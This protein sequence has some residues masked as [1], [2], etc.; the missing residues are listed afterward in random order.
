MGKDNQQN[1]SCPSWAVLSF[2]IGGNAFPL[3]LTISCPT[4]LSLCLFTFR[5]KAGCSQNTSMSWSK[6]SQDISKMLYSWEVGGNQDAPERH[7]HFHSNKLHKLG[8]KLWIHK[9]LE[10]YPKISWQQ[11]HYNCNYIYKKK[12]IQL[13]QQK[14]NADRMWK[15]HN[16]HAYMYTSNWWVTWDHK[17]IRRGHTTNRPKDHFTLLCGTGL[18]G[19]VSDFDTLIVLQFFT[20][21]LCIGEAARI[22]AS[23]TLNTDP[24]AVLQTS[25]SKLYVRSF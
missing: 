17:L 23:G 20:V 8:N 10:V 25:P 4:S 16:I 19:L 6:H 24:A 5:A 13:M 3:Q 2:T 18:W 1:S 11:I 9:L 22:K 15:L 12:S 14:H 21:Y 7:Q